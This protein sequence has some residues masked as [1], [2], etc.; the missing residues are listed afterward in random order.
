METSYESS[1]TSAYSEDLKWRVIWQ[2]DALGLKQRDIAV[3]LGVDSATVSR[4]LP[5]FRESGTVSKKNHPVPRV[6]KNLTAPLELTILH[7]SWR[8]FTRNCF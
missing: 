4:T 3:N 1:R 6:F 5:R 7:P 8:L 2:S